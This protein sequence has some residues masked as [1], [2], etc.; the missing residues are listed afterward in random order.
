M[1]EHSQ[2]TLLQKTVTLSVWGLVV[3]LFVTV[4]WPA[5]RPD[6]PLGAVS[7]FAR[8]GSLLMFVQVLVLAVG[9]A[10]FA[11]AIAGRL[12][13][14]VGTFAAALGLA[15]ATLSGHPA[16][17][18][19][20]SVA[21]ADRQYETTLA[22]SLAIESAAW[23]F[24]ILA[25]LIVSGVVTRFMM[26]HTRATADESAGSSE[27]EEEKL[28][29]VGDAPWLS[30]HVMKGHGGSRTK[31]EDGLRHMAVAAFL[32]VLFIALLSSGLATRTITHGQTCFIMAASMAMAY[33]FANRILP[34]Y[35][36]F[37]SLLAVP[38]VAIVGFAW[39]AVRPAEA[40]IPAIL[41]SS[42]FL[43]ILP[44]QYIAIGTAAVI[45]MSWYA[46]PPNAVEHG[47]D[48]APRRPVSAVS[49]RVS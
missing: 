34:V 6:D 17:A 37:W 42:H 41:P 19:I 28:L 7:L 43:R 22:T 10:A 40:H 45:A 13:A 15:I 12:L 24:V 16:G 21:D 27:R 4:G 23:F 49:G 1:D 30:E 44:V 38:L 36:P 11:T 3:A 2:L 26:S 31:P 33:H 8:G 39:A 46:L 35:S 20:V 25:C 18:L 47:R 32:G 5:M 29:A 9:A 14:D 48:R